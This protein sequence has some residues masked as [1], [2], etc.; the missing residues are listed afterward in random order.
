[1][2]HG[3]VARPHAFA[4]GVIFSISVDEE[5]RQ[6]FV[7]SSLLRRHLPFTARDQ[8]RVQYVTEHA[9]MLIEAAKKKCSGDEREKMIV[10][11]ESDY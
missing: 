5:V 6:V 1:M 3:F 7:S 2:P 10:L 4:D 9:R 11:D 8:D